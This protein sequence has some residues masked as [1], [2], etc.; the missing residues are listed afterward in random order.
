MHG[1]LNVKFRNSLHMLIFFN[2]FFFLLFLLSSAVYWYQYIL[3]LPQY[4]NAMLLIAY[5][6]FISHCMPHGVYSTL[7]DFRNV[8]FL[9]KSIAQFN[10]SLRNSIFFLAEVSSVSLYFTIPS[11]ATSGSA[12]NAVIFYFR[13]M[14]N[15]PKYYLP[16]R[17]CNSAYLVVTSKRFNPA[18][19]TYLLTYSME[20]ILSWE[21]NSFSASQEILRILWNPKVH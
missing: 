16:C 19:L 13:L 4:L 15:I 7:L 20:H 14:H 18:V 3:L 6:F 9:D 5:I 21:A 2:L 11:A 1:H 8:V 17:T 12:F 10:P